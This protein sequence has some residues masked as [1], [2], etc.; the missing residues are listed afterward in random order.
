M[1]GEAAVGLFELSQPFLALQ[2]QA[3]AVDGCRQ[4]ICQQLHDGSICGR[5]APADIALQI[6]QAD[7]ALTSAE[8]QAQLR[9]CRRGW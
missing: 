7:G 5:E 3:A 2:Q 8:G 4:L 9:L 6:E 1:L